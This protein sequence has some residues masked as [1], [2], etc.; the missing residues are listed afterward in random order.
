MYKNNYFSK[1]FVHI[2]FFTIFA[3]K[4]MYMK[5]KQDIKIIDD[6]VREEMSVYGSQASDYYGNRI[7]LITNPDSMRK[8]L[9]NNI[10]RPFL[11]KEARIMLVT[12]GFIVEEHNMKQRTI[13]RGM[14]IITPYNCFMNVRQVSSDFNSKIVAFGF[15]HENLIKGFTSNTMCFKVSPSNE[16]VLSH[17]FDLFEACIQNEVTQHQVLEPIVY[18]FANLINSLAKENKQNIEYEER[19]LVNRF[20]SLLINRGSRREKI[21]YYAKLLNVSVN[22]LGA[23]V[24]KE[25]GRT[26]LQ[27]INERTLLEAKTK[28]LHSNISSAHIAQMLG[29]NTA[30]QFG[31]FFRKATGITPA[32]YRKQKGKEVEGV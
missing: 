18:S 22:Y 1:N 9:E 7:V 21:S 28:L 4:L 27:W 24:K 30:S 13:E 16:Y 14:L 3:K 11:S 26:A 15:V 19:S 29:F 12:S 23:V 17:F 8:F 10:H 2:Y 25:T 32:E 31:T 5:I 20:N 6:T